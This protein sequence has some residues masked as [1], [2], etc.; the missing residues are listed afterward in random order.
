M[1]EYIHHTKRDNYFPEKSDL[2]KIT[3]SS[4]MKKIMKKYF[5]AAGFH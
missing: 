2:E 5:V 1:C 4:Q 3:I